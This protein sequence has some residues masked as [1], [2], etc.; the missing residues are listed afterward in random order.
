VRTEILY[1]SCLHRTPC[2]TCS[3]NIKNEH[4]LDGIEE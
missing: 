1:G 2:A 4:C 3:E